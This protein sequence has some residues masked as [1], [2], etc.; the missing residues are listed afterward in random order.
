M[1]YCSHVWGA[2]PPS[3]LGILDSIQKRAIR[4]INDPGLVGRLPTLA[5]RRDVPWETFLFSTDIFTAFAQKNW[6]LFFPHWLFVTEWQEESCT[7]ILIPSSCRSLEHP[8]TY[9]SSYPECQDYGTSGLQIFF[10]PLLTF[11]PLN[12]VYT[13][14]TCPT[15]RQPPCASTWAWSFRELSK[16]KKY[17]LHKNRQGSRYTWQYR[18]ESFAPA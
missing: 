1:E 4:L 6:L 15:F 13:D 9:V 8:I 5:H 16:I 17:T 18:S 12:P 11:N 2:A 14:C 10:H 7:C 3:T